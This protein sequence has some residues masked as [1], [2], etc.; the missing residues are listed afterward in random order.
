M[1]LP[2]IY[3]SVLQAASSVMETVLTDIDSMFS[4]ELHYL[5]IRGRGQGEAQEEQ[6]C[7]MLSPPI[8]AP[9]ILNKL[10]MR[11]EYQDKI[12]LDMLEGDESGVDLKPRK[13]IGEVEKEEGMLSES[14][15]SGE[16]WAEGRH[17]GHWRWS[18]GILFHCLKLLKDNWYWNVLTWL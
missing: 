1:F 11:F 6:G 12:W 7:L 9:L 2:C 4:P 13:I 14:R 5:Y 17:L 8:W 16:N 15:K 18:V 10:G 3:G